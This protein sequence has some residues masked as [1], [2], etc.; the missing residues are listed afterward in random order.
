[1]A[2]HHLESDNMTKAPILVSPLNVAGQSSSISIVART[3]PARALV[4]RH[5]HD[6]A[7]LIHG[8]AGV[9]SVQTSQGT[10]VVPPARA[11][12]VPAHT[13]HEI[14]AFGEV[15]M[16]S[17]DLATSIFPGLPAESCCVVAVTDFMRHLVLRYEQLRDEPDGRAALLI[18]ELMVIELRHLPVAPL[19]LPMPR[20]ARLRVVCV[21]IVDAP[22]ETLT[23]EEWGRRVGA[24]SRTLARKFVA[25]TGMNFD[26]W[27][28]QARLLD[29]LARLAAGQPILTIALELGYNSPSA[30][31]AMFKR[32]FGCTPRDYFRQ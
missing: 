24:S 17:L 15:T 14:R 16:R 26:R 4:P 10:W 21:G 23:L 1:M 30:F 3:L 32:A 2:K 27:R 31:S 9:M 20:D 18:R 11:I 22:G 8:I 12:W 29:A 6:H 7:R 28:Q 13:D 19:H 25:E 5:S